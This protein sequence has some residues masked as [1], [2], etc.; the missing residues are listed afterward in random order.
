MTPKTGWMRS[1]RQLHRYIK[2]VTRPTPGSK[3]ELSPYGVCGLSIKR[4]GDRREEICEEV[5]QRADTAGTVT[6]RGQPTTRSRIL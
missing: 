1:T 4:T 3:K 5:L 6:D 2:N